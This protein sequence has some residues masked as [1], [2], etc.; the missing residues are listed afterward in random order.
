MQ[1][2]ADD[3]G[4][5][6]EEPM[7]RDSEEKFYKAF[8][9]SS[10]IMVLFTVLEGRII[11]ANESAC[12]LTGYGAHELIGSTIIDLDLY[13][14]RSQRKKIQTL[15]R[16]TGHIENVELIVKNKAGETRYAMF[17]M[18]A[19]MIDDELC[20]LAVGSD[21]T[22]RKQAEQALQA[23]YAEQGRQKDIIEKKS[24]ELEAAKKR[25]EQEARLVEES[26][27]HKSEFLAG[28]SHEL[29]TP[30]N[31]I[32]LLSELLARN[33]SGRLSDKEAEYAAVIRDAGRDLLELIN[34]LLDLSRLEAGRMEVHLTRVSIEYFCRKISGYFREMA[35]VKGLAFDIRPQ[36][37]LTGTFVTDI[38]KLE[39]IVRNLVANAVKFTHRG[40]VRLHIRRPDPSEDLSMIGLAGLAHEKTL[41]F[42]VEDSG[43]GIDRAKWGMIFEQYRQA[44]PH[45]AS[46]YGGTGL[47]LPVSR[48][49]AQLLGG[50]IL[51]ESSPGRGSVFT[52]YLP[53][54]SFDKSSKQP[55]DAPAPPG[56]PAGV[57]SADTGRFLRGKVLVL[58]DDDM[59]TVYALIQHLQPFG[60][61]IIVAG[62]GAKC[63]KRLDERRHVDLLILDIAMPECDGL[64]VLGQIRGHP[65][66][67]GLPVIVISARAMA[68][69]REA[70]EAAGASAF[71]S[72]PLDLHA[73]LA[74][75][76]RLLGTGEPHE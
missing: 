66:L 8:H 48:V 21:F 1:R 37:G 20:V 69:D 23:A 35:E 13:P 38:Q 15:I 14:E 73:L 65:R 74:A 44:E 49:L 61:E 68:A 64:S 4:R 70:A 40:Y 32:I 58:A 51:V 67:S 50:D 43:I 28:M 7:L 3:P 76:A 30:L 57:P 9:S 18:D 60:P 62:D 59:R 25:I 36:T 56:V 31:S 52:L 27:R 71:L 39:Q 16:D 10:V 54:H 24:R 5:D 45:T 75:A 55:V 26:S 53:D 46:Q 22:E 47:G 17:S 6:G 33:S 11:D 12:R 29:R 19:L 42:V 72:K 63:L 41:A 34:D 2:S